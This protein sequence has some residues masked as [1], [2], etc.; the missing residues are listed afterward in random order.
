MK[1]FLLE[2]GLH[3]FQG[4]RRRELVVTNKIQM[5]GLLKNRLPLTANEGEIW[6][7]LQS[8]RRGRKILSWPNQNPP[9]S[10]EN[11]TGYEANCVKRGKREWLLIVYGS[12]LAS[13]RQI[14]EELFTILYF[15]YNFNLSSCS[16]IWW[17]ITQSTLILIPLRPNPMDWLWLAFSLRYV[18]KYHICCYTNFTRYFVSDEFGKIK[19]FP[20]IA[21]VPKMKGISRMVDR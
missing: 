6:A 20:G 19:N 9:A 10:V 21:S 2:D 8:L 16:S 14:R 17:L 18:W 5:G 1:V 4:K 3:G 11:M 15:M 12:S 13:G 7:Y